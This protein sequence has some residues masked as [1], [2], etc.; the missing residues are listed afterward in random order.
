MR[1]I[2]WLWYGPHR[3]RKPALSMRLPGGTRPEDVCVVTREG[4]FKHRSNY[5]GSVPM[6]YYMLP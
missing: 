4:T 6:A 2:V 1:W 5:P 3:V